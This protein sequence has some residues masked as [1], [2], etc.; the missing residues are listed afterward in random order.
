M[1]QN[2]RFTNR[3]EEQV[4]ETFY[5]QL[6][7]IYVIRFQDACPELGITSPQ[8][9]AMAEIHTCNHNTKK[10]LL[11]NR[12]NFF[13]K[14]GRHNVVDLKC[15]QNLVGRVDAGRG[16]TAVLDRTGSVISTIAT[17]DE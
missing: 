7:H 9:I 11:D 3:A 12:I 1:D 10:S 16:G 4:T 2:A 5:G 15:V 8:V 17:V 13:S 14:M 6:E